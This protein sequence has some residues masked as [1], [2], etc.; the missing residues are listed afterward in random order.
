[1]AATG[2]DSPFAVAPDA[3]DAARP[4]ATA[5]DPP[6]VPVA[7]PPAPNDPFRNIAAPQWN[8]PAPQGA[9]TSGAEGGPYVQNRGPAG[10]VG[11]IP[12][13]GPSKD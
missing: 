11:W 1:L 4:T 3:P 10:P 9:D 13:G 8:C 6:S 7:P 12:H 5:T 2:T